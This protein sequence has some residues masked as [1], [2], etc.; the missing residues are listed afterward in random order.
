MHRWVVNDMADSLHFADGL[1]LGCGTMKNR[2]LFRTRTYTGVDLDS[3]RIAEGL[4]LYPEARGKVGRIEDTD[5]DADYVLCLQTICTNKYFDVENTLPV[6]ETMVASTRPGGVLIFNVGKHCRE[7]EAIDAFLLASFATVEKKVYGNL[8]RPLP[9]LLSGFLGRLM[10]RFPALRTNSR[11][12][13]VYYCCR[14]RLSSNEADAVLH[15][16]ES[17]GAGDGMRTRTNQ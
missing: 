15:S 2:L 9:V 16:P 17:R 5:L 13:E 14:G 1:D 3:A 4:R 8:A 11:R 12:R 10:N 6:V 7:E